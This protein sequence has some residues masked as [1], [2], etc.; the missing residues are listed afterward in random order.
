MYSNTHRIV[1]ILHV[2]NQ[3]IA[4]SSQNSNSRSKQ[5]DKLSQNSDSTVL[6]RLCMRSPILDKSRQNPNTNSQSPN[7]EVS[8]NPESLSQNSDQFSQTPGKRSAALDWSDALLWQPRRVM[9]VHCLV[10]GLSQSLSVS[11]LPLVKPVHTSTLN[12]RPP[13]PIVCTHTHTFK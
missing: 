6:V 10:N 9:L 4:E 1:Q 8:H 2:C 13:I 7:K 5:P 3:I 11:V 12:R